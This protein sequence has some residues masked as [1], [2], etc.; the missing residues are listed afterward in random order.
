MTL[1]APAP[2]DRKGLDKRSLDYILRSGIAGGLAG[3]AVGGLF[4]SLLTIAR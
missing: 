1:K 2:H 3:C 4:A